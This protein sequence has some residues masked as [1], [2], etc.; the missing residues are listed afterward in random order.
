MKRIRIRN[1]DFQMRVVWR[2]LE[3]YT[4]LGALRNKTVLQMYLD[5]S[6]NGCQNNNFSIDWANNSD[7]ER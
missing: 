6:D 1:T 3:D 4:R 2:F 7:F 5:M